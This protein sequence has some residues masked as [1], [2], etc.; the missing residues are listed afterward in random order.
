MGDSQYSFSLT[1][2]SP[3]GKLVQIEQALTAVGSGQTSLGIKAANGVVIA[4]EKKLPSILVDESSVI[5]L[6]TFPVNLMAYLPPHKRYSKDVRRAS[7]I[8]ETLHPRFKR[9]MNLRASTSHL[10]KSGKIVYA[11]RCISKWF[12][13]GL[14]DDDNFPPHIHLQPISLEY[15]DRKSGEKP[16]VLVNSVA[17]EEDSKLER[18]CSRSPW[19]VIAEEVQQELLSSFEILRNEMDDQGSERVKPTLVAR[20]GKFLFHG[21]RSIALESVDKIQVEEAILRQLKRSLYTNIPS[22]YMEN[23]IDGVVPVIGVDFEEEK[24]VYHVKLSDNTRPDTTISCKCSVLENKKLLLYK[25]GFVLPRVLSSHVNLSY[26]MVELNQV[27]QMVIDVSCLDKNLDLRLMLST[28]K[29]LT[30]LTDDEMN[31]ITDLINSAVLDSDAKGGLRWP[32]GKASSGGRYSVTGAWHTVTK[33]YKSSSFRLKVRD[34]DR[35]DFRSGAG[36]AAREIYLKLKRIVSEI[37]ASSFIGFYFSLCIFMLLCLILF[38]RY[39]VS[40][41]TPDKENMFCQNLLFFLCGE[42]GAEGDSIS[43]M[44]ED[45]LRLIWD[46][47]LCCERFLT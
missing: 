30:T 22:S 3:T 29:I 38:S 45:S 19:E 18:N 32:L 2:F 44:L 36:E 21:S 14:D 33:A 10:D 5:R 16:L 7:P 8:P 35:F 9:N 41:F 23:I 43:K 47:F 34:A 28:K 13:V 25:A 15:V 24:D 39:F 40:D 46:K 26:Y 11:D 27:R 17:T 31:S 12:A 37:Q 42:P 20:L 6:H 1:S 4:T